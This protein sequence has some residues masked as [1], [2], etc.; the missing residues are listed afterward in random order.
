MSVTAWRWCSP[1]ATR[2]PHD[3][4]EAIDVTY[5]PLEA[6]TDLEDALSDRV[7]VHEDL[8]TNSSYT[9]NLLVEESDGAVQRAFDEAAYT[10][11]ERYVQQRL[12]PMGHGTPR[13]RRGAP[14]VRR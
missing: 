9:W 13:R 11:S 10:V 2:S 8:G 14:A 3:A 4:I 12:I 5:D 7:I 6:V 1:T